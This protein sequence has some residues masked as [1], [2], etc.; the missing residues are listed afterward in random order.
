MK[1][2]EKGNFEIKDTIL[3][4]RDIILPPS[5]EDRTMDDPIEQTFDLSSFG[6]VTILYR[7]YDG[8]TA[9]A[10]VY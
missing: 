7:E 5:E 6:D 4:R 2:E 1:N 10:L 8:F 3:I 9:A